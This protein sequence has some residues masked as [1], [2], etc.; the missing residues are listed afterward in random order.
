MGASLCARDGDRL[1]PLVVRGGRLRATQHVLEVASAQ[2]KSAILLAGLSADGDTVVIEPERSRDHTERML[3]GMGVPVKVDGLMVTLSPA[4]PRGTRVD[5]PGDISSA[6]F[7]LCAAAGLPGS[8]VTVRNLGVNETRTGLL[9]VLAAMGA[10]VERRG[11]RLVAGEARADVTVRAGELRAAEIHGPL[12]P[13]LI[14]EL[15]VLMV[16]ATQ[17][18]GRTLIRDARE[19]RVKESDRL[20][21]M[22]ETLAAAGARIE[23]FDDGCA[24]EGPTP[25]RGVAVKTRLDHRIAMSMAVAQLLAGPAEEVLLDD[26]A[27]VATSFPT[28]F[29]LLDGL[30]GGAR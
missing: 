14:D 29:E 28:F 30:C 20:A 21:A 24:I 10:R 6:A 9:E 4:R 3:S 2:V 22:G 15:P 1:P 5:V 12:V 19:L 23:L 18:R 25:L 7:F 8:E 11:E 26:V 13:R 27:C 17:A 16:L